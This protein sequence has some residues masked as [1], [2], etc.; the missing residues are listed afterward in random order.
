MDKPS[1]KSDVKFRM[2]KLSI[3]LIRF[4]GKLPKDT[5]LRII[6]DQLIRSTTSIGANVV[7]AK[8][9]SSKKEFTHY[10][11]IALKSANESKYWIEMLV[12]VYPSGKDDLL[13]YHREVD[14]LS[15]ILGSSILTMKGKR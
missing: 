8:S 2:L 15:K 5:A 6:S 4:L 11:Q 7:E 3:A 12:E 13:G 10:F 9:S 14:E 1:T